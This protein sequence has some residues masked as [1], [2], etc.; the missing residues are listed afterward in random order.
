M[1]RCVA[2]LFVIAS[3]GPAEQGEPGPEGPAG[4][5]G[6]QG[7]TGMAG[8]RGDVGPSGTA[9]QD[10][11]EVVSTGQLQ[12]TAATTT[13]TPVPGLLVSLDVPASSRLR[14]HTDGGIQCTAT[15]SAYAAVDVALF[16]D[17]VASPQGGQRR[18]VAANTAAVAQMIANWSFDRIY[19]LAPGAHTFEV[20]AV[21]ADP[22]SATANVAS[23]S[24]PQI[25]A[26]LSVTV[27]RR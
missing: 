17:G 2:L 7:P 15:G 20:R 19:T 18:V 12:V 23:G 5:T 8:E 22:G 21:S 24:A 10:I 3:C 16:V 27:L 4:P 14:V 25:Q 11:V 9:G 26:T 13:F 1:K 6:P